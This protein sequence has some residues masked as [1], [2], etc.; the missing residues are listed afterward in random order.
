MEN[1]NKIKKKETTRLITESE[2][3]SKLDI[4][5]DGQTGTSKQLNDIRD[6]L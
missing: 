4:L 1:K 3:E 5:V 6:D 2:V